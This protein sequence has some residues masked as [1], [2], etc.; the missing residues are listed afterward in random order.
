MN[1]PKSRNLV[2]LAV[3]LSVFLAI[4]CTTAFVAGL[5]GEK[6]AAP[7]FA[8]QGLVDYIGHGPRVLRLDPASPEAASYVADGKYDLIE[9][10][11]PTRFP[12]RDSGSSFSV[13]PF[14]TQRII[15][16]A[17]STLSNPGILVVSRLEYAH[18]HDALRMA[19]TMAAAL[20]EQG[21]EDISNHF[22]IVSEQYLDQDGR[23]VMIL[24]SK[25]NLTRE[26]E[27]RA[28]EYLAAHKDLALIYS[29][30]YRAEAA[31]VHPVDPNVRWNPF[32]A[33]MVSGDPEG[34]AQKY[35]MNVS[36]ITRNH[37]FYFFTV[38]LSNIWRRSAFV[39]PIDWSRH[40]NLV[41]LAI[42]VAVSIVLWVGA[43]LTMGKEHLA[44][45]LGKQLVVA[46]TVALF[47]GAM[48]ALMIFADGLVLFRRSSLSL[49]AAV[50]YLGLWVFFF[51]K[52]Q[53]ARP[54]R[55][56]PQIVLVCISSIAVGS[57]F[58]LW[59]A[60]SWGLAIT[61]LIAFVLFTSGF[62][63]F[64]TLRER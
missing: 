7:T 3:A 52:T 63:L 53:A 11:N 31:G 34:F 10:A 50:T 36:P 21:A 14:Y 47:G 17:F 20:R 35:Q 55:V 38:K 60:L 64:A 44:R 8:A 37:P 61:T 62:L 13:V 22:L 43:V 33:L 57:V 29:P 42:M 27:Q 9:V 6:E 45:G 5:I 4:T 23:H 16:T 28:F 46:L 51:G 15:E 49:I 56:T 48:L 30:H 24:A 25:E 59:A 40:K 2:L 19:S 18:A 39:T 12:M 1:A 32:A 58:S 26:R 41:V 54:F